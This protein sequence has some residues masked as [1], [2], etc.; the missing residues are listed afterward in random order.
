MRFPFLHVR[1]FGGVS[2]S[3]FSRA[4]FQLPR[5]PWQFPSPT[6]ASADSCLFT[7][8]VVLYGAEQIPALSAFLGF[9]SPLQAK[10]SS[11]R[12]RDIR[13]PVAPAGNLTEQKSVPHERQASPDKDIDFRGPSA[14]FTVS[15]ESRALTCCAALPGNS[16]LYDV[17]VRR[18]TVLH[19]GFLQTPPCGDA[20]AFG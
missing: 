16:A 9:V 10:T 13:A 5:R 12:G 6:M 15:P 17:S 8:Q 18:L 2:P 4:R 11:L 1:P 14:P 19:S 7:I 20:L 3:L